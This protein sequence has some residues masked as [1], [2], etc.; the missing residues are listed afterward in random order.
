MADL[1]TI[2]AQKFPQA[3]IETLNGQLTVTVDDKDWHSLARTL[4]DLE[5]TPQDFLVTIVGMD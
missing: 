1:Q 2:I 5:D 3:K 4:R